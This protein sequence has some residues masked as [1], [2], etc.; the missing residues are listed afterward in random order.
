MMKTVICW[1]VIEFYDVIN[2]S[3]SALNCNIY[4]NINGFK[5]S[6]HEIINKLT[7]QTIIYFRTLNVLEVY[8]HI[9]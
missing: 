9:F 6:V 3:L 4:R 5:C 1:S 7:P 8:H 2:L